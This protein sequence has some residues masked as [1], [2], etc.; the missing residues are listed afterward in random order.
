MEL[1][2]VPEKSHGN[3]YEGDCYVLLHVSIAVARAG[4][5]VD[6]GLTITFFAHRSMASGFPESLTSATLLLSVFFIYHDASKL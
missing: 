4:C 2:L 6:Q 3:F 1:V 5:G